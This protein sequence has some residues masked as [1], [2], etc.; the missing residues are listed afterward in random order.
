MSGIETVRV[1]AVKPGT[2]LYPDGDFYCMALNTAKEVK[3]DPHGLFVECSGGKHYLDGQLS[4]DR[5]FY[6]GLSLSKWPEPH[7][8]EDEEGASK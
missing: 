1:S 6:V 2:I 4:D 7:Q 8:D 5:E 3:F